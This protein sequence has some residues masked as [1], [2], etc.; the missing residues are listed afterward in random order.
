MSGVYLLHFDKP[1]GHARHY[2]GYT[3]DD[4]PSRRVQEHLS[5]GHR[6]NPL[7]KAAVAAGR[8]VELAHFIPGADRTFERKLKNWGGKAKWCPLCGVNTRPL[9]TCEAA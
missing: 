1:F 5:G 7:V 4:D 9:P 8:K 6:A 2:L 3:E